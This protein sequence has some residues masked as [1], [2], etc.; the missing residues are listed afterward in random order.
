L[1]VAGAALL[2]FGAAMC[3]TKDW[4][5]VEAVR[6]W[7]SRGEFASAPNLFQFQSQ[8]GALA[9]F[10]GVLMSPAARRVLAGDACCHLGR[11]SFGIYLLHF[12]ILF[13]LSAAAFVDLRRWLPHGASVAGAFAVLFVATLAASVLFERWIDRP[14]IRFSRSVGAFRWGS[15]S[16]VVHAPSRGKKTEPAA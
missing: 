16:A 2:V 8:L 14:A 7:L 9:L 6:V 11:L 12:P 1:G 10:C 13:T 5:M 3:A 15:V 4:S